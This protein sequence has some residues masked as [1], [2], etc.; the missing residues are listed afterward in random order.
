M[1]SSQDS[2]EEKKR[3]N[4]WTRYRLTLEEYED[5]TKRNGGLCEI[6]N[7]RR[8]TCV[9]HCH[10]TGDVRGHLCIGCN[11]A[12]ATLGDNEAGLMRALDYLGKENGYPTRDRVFG[13]R[14]SE[15]L[16]QDDQR[17]ADP[18]VCRDV[19]SSPAARPK[20]RG[21]DVHAGT[22]EQ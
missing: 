14:R 4:L 8:A 6:C 16:P 19:R 12:L 17:R 7:E 21:Q 9:D 13:A 20:R 3:R 11:R 10:D 18:G 22:D 1:A 15:T 5:L 2:G